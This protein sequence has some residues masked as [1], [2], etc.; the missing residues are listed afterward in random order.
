MQGRGGDGP[1]MILCIPNSP[2]P[3]QGIKQLF[4]GRVSIDVGFRGSRFYFF[5][6]LKGFYLFDRERAQAGGAAGKVR[7]RSRLPTEQGAL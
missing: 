1:T 2:G 5:K 3:S 4:R 6:I 7:G